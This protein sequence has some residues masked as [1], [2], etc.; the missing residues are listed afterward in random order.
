[1]MSY[2]CVFFFFFIWIKN[3]NDA[4]SET[5]SPKPT[6]RITVNIK[7]IIYND[8]VQPLIIIRNAGTARVMSS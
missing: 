4:S 5:G 6:D 8:F 2:V 7:V 1:M 3:Q